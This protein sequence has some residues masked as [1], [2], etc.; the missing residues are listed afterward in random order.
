VVATALSLF[1]CA[2]L[3]SPVVTVLHS[4]PVPLGGPVAS[5]V[6]ASDGNYYGV[7]NA[8][9]VFLYMMSP[10]GATTIL[11]TFDCAVC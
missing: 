7:A 1:P 3:A 10:A 4:F 6:A 5:L 2:T 8:G 9:N 11:H